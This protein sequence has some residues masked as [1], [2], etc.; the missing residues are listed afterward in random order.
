MTNQFTAAAILQLE[1]KGVLNVE[2]TLNKYISNYPKGDTITIYELL[3]HTSGIPNYS[4]FDDYTITSKQNYT[5][6]KKQS[7]ALKISL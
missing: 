5:L 2:D 3:S 7:I 1:D 6:Q 4:S